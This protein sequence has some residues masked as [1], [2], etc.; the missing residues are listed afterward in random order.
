MRVSHLQ[1]EE[2]RRTKCE[3]GTRFLCP[4][5]HVCV[6]ERCL[7]CGN[8]SCVERREREATDTLIRAA[9]STD[10]REAGDM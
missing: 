1:A 2:K 7:A 3:S 10:Q 4:V 6:G 8:P 5:Q 9:N